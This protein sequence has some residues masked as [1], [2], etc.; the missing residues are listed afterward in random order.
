MAPV[1]LLSLRE[2]GQRNAS[3]ATGWLR[4]NQRTTA[5]TTPP[6]GTW[7]SRG[8]HV[9]LAAVAIRREQRKRSTPAPATAEVSP[10]PLASQWLGDVSA[11]RT[12]SV[13]GQQPN[14]WSST[15]QS[16]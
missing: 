15:K 14:F 13:L 6:C 2:R 3:L 8:G 12:I 11:A 7:S 5:G 10:V 4:M 16:M 9:G 1:A